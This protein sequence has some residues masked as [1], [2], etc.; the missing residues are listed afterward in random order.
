MA[1]SQEDEVVLDEAWLSDGEA[2]ERGVLV[3]QEG[4]LHALR[5]CTC[6]EPWTERQEFRNH[7]I[8][9]ETGE[10]GYVLICTYCGQLWDHRRTNEIINRIINKRDGEAGAE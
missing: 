2:W 10:R 9:A 1:T 7:I 6:N 4:G 8:N 5:R 3:A